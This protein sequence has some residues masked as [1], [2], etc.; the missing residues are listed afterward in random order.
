MA[1][2]TVSRRAALTLTVAGAAATVA[3]LARAGGWPSTGEA[4]PPRA[5]PVLEPSRPIRI[6]I[7]SI[8]VRARV[9]AVGLA[10]DGSIAAPPLR[11]HRE[12]AWFDRSPTPG[13]YG[14]SVI[15]GHTDTTSGPSVFHDLPRLRRRARIEVTRRDRRVAVF[16]VNSVERFG[17]TRLPTERVYGDFSRPC[18]R[19]ITCGGRWVGGRTGYTD[20]I[21][22]FASLVDARDP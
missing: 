12:A 14:P 4:P 10:P 9:H 2:P 11:R 3:G 18:L 7:P 15:V 6:E 22:V 20:N 21:V 5:F 1:G 17:K 19:L 8:K 16:E 13:Q